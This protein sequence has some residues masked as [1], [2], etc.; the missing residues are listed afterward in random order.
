MLAPLMLWEFE[1]SQMDSNPH[2]FDILC[3]DVQEVTS[4]KKE[5]MEEDWQIGATP[6][7]QHEI[8]I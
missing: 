5:M 6:E 4:H 7:S 3:E 1:R 2:H 8:A